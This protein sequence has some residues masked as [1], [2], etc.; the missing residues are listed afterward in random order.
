LTVLR[1]LGS[2]IQFMPDM[3][4][5]GQ[6]TTLEID[7][8]EEEAEIKETEEDGGV[9]WKRLAKDVRFIG[10]GGSLMSLTSLRVGKARPQFISALLPIPSLE[11]LHIDEGDFSALSTE[12]FR[13]LCANLSTGCPSFR[14]LHLADRRLFENAE[15][16]D[17]TLSGLACLTQL[18]VLILDRGLSCSNSCCDTQFLRPEQ[19]P[20]SALVAKHLLPH[21]LSLMVLQSLQIHGFILD[22]DAV[23]ALGEL[24]ARNSDLA[25]ISLK[26]SHL[27][28]ESSHLALRTLAALPITP[29]HHITHR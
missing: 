29:G 26:D 21:M 8:V 12:S 25:N 22:Q 7:H 15:R 20:Q 13:A 14:V 10:L 6:L 28:G 18:H 16:T 3:H 5:F 19:R 24:V 17:H 9:Y 23:L 11:S 27:I 2:S 4:P 1:L